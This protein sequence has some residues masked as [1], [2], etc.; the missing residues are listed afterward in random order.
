VSDAAPL[1]V[2]VIAVSA[3]IGGGGSFLVNQMGALDRGPG[4]SL[5]IHCSEPLGA[6][7]RAA[8][9]R[10]QVLEHP[11]RPLPVRL[12]HEHVRLAALSRRFDVVY[13]PGNLGLLRS[14]APMV[15]CQQNA[16]YFT[17]GVR[18]FR[19]ERCSRKLRA[20]VAVEAAVNRFTLRRA[21]AAVAVSGT[22]RAMIEEDLGPLPHL[23]TVLSAPPRSP[24]ERADDPQPYALAVAHDDPHK[25][26]DGLVEAFTRHPD[27]PPL[28]IVGRV[29]PARRSAL[30]ARAAG[31]VR[32]DGQVSDRDELAR[33]YAGAACTLAHSAFESY[34]LTPAEALVCGSPVAATDIPAHRE[35]CGELAQ[36][37]PV[38]DLD[39][40]AHAVRRALAGPRPAPEDLG[41][42]L[43]RT[44]DENAA[45][46]AGVL[47][48]VSRPAAGTAGPRRGTARR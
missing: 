37:Y 39:G 42:P 2:L 18:A 13:V 44:W 17:D 3:R 43:R 22:L 9:P 10:A 5:T 28:R 29:S 16:W 32:V 15:V 41:A 23:R 8:A 26:Y 19:R 27:L 47:R 1:S 7:L 35:V 24:R 6:P 14:F 40:L 36:L 25:D 21:A 12:L 11:R 33:L 34:G 20:R 4:V 38:G 31:R 46:L 30:E 48:A 45:E